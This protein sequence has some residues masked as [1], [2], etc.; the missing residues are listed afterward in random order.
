[1]TIRSSAVG[2][3]VMNS[4]R[5]SP[6]VGPGQNLPVWPPTRNVRYGLGRDGGAVETAEVVIAVPGAAGSGCGGA[7]P[8][9]SVSILEGEIVND[10]A[11]RASA[12]GS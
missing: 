11:G 9:S 5:T 10:R 3:Q 1:M 8:V 4:C 7:G 12:P 6:R 2:R